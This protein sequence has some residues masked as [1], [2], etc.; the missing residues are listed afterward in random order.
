MLSQGGAGTPNT[1]QSI[2]NNNAFTIRSYSLNSGDNITVTF[3]IPQDFIGNIQPT[4]I[5]HFYTQNSTQSS[6]NVEISLSAIFVPAAGANINI[7]E[8]VNY[9]G[10]IVPVSPAPIVNSFNH[11]S[12]SFTLNQT[13]AAGDFAL[14][15]AFR[16]VPTSGTD[17]S[18]HIF[19]TSIEFRY[20]S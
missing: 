16:I 4:V 3:N 11:Y 2:G 13:I 20:A 19:L 7:S 12:V 14:I 17:F 1:N 5:I 10:T 15:S 6:N 9:S 8:V 18:D